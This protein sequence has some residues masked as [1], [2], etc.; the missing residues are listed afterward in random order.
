MNDRMTDEE[1]RILIETE[2]RSKS[3]T[4]LIAEIKEDINEMKS[5]QKAIYDIS[6]NIQLMTQNMNFMKTDISDVKS[7]V[8]GIKEKVVSLENKP[9]K[10]TQVRLNKVTD[11]L[12]WLLIGGIAAYLA[13]QILPAVF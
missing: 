2:Q 8:G 10:D 3:N 12:I 9:A 13:A 6:T 4:C 7:E 1:T 5:E 11:N